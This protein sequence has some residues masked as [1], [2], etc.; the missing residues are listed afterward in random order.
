MELVPGR[1]ENADE[2]LHHL[3]IALRPIIDSAIGGDVASESV[4]REV[5]RLVRPDLYRLPPR[6][7]R[8]MEFYRLMGKLSYVVIPIE[9]QSL[10]RSRSYVR[11]TEDKGRKRF[12]EYDL[13]EQHISRR[14]KPFT[15]HTLTISI[16]IEQAADKG[17]SG[18]NQRTIE[19]DLRLARLYHEKQKRLHRVPD[20][21]MLLSNGESLPFYNYSE[22]WR[23]RKSYTVK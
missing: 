1:K 6:V 11:L 17:L 3:M 21:Y 2:I 4:V 8:A 20:Y 5:H 7:A 22:D 15:L 12:R 13:A 23:R 18:I 16:F 9:G 14:K 19:G 10:L